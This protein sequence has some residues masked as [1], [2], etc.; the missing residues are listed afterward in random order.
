MDSLML[1]KT[2]PLKDLAQEIVNNSP[3]KLFAIIID[4]QQE[5][6]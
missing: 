4:I 6:L 5:V 2:L 1:L 3:E